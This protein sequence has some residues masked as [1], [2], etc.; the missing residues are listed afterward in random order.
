[1]KMTVLTP[2]HMNLLGALF[3]IS[4]RMVVLGIA[5]DVLHAAKKAAFK[6]YPRNIFAMKITLTQ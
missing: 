5:P 1:M 6:N 4:N 2:Q 3:C